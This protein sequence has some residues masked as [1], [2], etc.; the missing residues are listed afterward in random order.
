MKKY[1]IKEYDY[2]THKDYEVQRKFLNL[3]WYNPSNIDANTSGFF[4]TIESAEKFI[5]S[6]ISLFPITTIIKTYNV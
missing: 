5:E 4:N 6:N 3:F 2:G 1:R